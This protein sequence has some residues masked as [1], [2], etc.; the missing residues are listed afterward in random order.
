MYLINDCYIE[1][2]PLKHFILM[3]LIALISVQVASAKGCEQE[4]AASIESML[5]KQ[6][7]YL[8]QQTDPRYPI[9]FKDAFVDVKENSDGSYSATYAY[10]FE[11][12]LWVGR[13]ELTVVTLPFDANCREVK[14]KRDVKTLKI[15]MSI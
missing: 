12:K 9:L 11:D 15:K 1:G 14:G 5:Q 13:E 7:R 2:D 4:I 10:K 6:V 8:N 3:G